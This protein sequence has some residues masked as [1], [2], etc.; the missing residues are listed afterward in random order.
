[1]IIRDSIKLQYGRLKEETAL[2]I[3]YKTHL[4]ELTVNLAACDAARPL[5]DKL[6]RLCE[7]KYITLD[8]YNAARKEAF[9]T[10][11]NE[12]NKLARHTAATHIASALHTLG[13]TVI[14][15]KDS[16]EDA[17]TAFEA[18]AVT[19]LKTQ[20][21]N[22][23]V[24]LKY[25]EDGSVAARLVR[26]AASDKEKGLATP[27]VKA[28]TSAYQ[29]QKD[30]ETTR[31]WCGHFDHFLNELKDKGIGFNVELRKEPGDEDILVITDA[32]IAEA[33]HEATA[34]QTET[35]TSRAV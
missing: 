7:N 4:Q 3:V 34:R 2:S 18:G 33:S 29:R 26:V 15:G 12:E 19:Y 27:G 9:D 8:E 25:N 17:L 13:Y 31:K 24:M 5:M 23:L 22:Y 10:L 16:P 11:L 1:M 21:L 6:A 35:D 14:T 32:A 20:W 30:I 28:A